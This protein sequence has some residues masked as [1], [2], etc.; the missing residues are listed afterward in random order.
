MYDWRGCL[1]PKLVCYTNDLQREK[2]TLRPSSSPPIQVVHGV[3]RNATAPLP[4]PQLSVR[5][6]ELCLCE[7][8][9]IQ[10]CSGAT[11]VLLKSMGFGNVYNEYVCRILLLLAYVDLGGDLFAEMKTFMKKNTESLPG[12]AHVA[13]CRQGRHSS[14]LHAEVVTTKVVPDLLNLWRWQTFHGTEKGASAL[15]ASRVEHKPKLNALACMADQAGYLRPCP[16]RCGQHCHCLLQ[17]TRWH[18]LVNHSWSCDS[19]DKEHVPNV[20]AQLHAKAGKAGGAAHGVLRSACL[21]AQLPTRFENQ[22]TLLACLF[23]SP[24][25]DMFA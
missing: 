6:N 7:Y 10:L 17:V 3:A 11:K 9:C 14:P 8:R 20:T 1:L 22:S 2:L 16:A 12:E 15:P 18:C 13:P 21:L 24:A 5:G 4:L 19:G 23:M 25:L